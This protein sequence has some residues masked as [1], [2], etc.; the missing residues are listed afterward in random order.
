MISYQYMPRSTG[1][2]DELIAVSSKSK[3]I[4]KPQPFAPEGLLQLRAQLSRY[5]FMHL[6]SPL[7]LEGWKL[8]YRLWRR[9]CVLKSR[10]ARLSSRSKC[11]Q[12]QMLQKSAKK[13]EL[14]HSVA[15]A[16]E[17]VQRQSF[18]MVLGTIQRH[19]WRRGA[20][21]VVNRWKGFSL[22]TFNFWTQRKRSFGEDGDKQMV[23]PVKRQKQEEKQGEG[24]E[25]A[26]EK[27]NDLAKQV[28]SSWKL[29]HNVSVGK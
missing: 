29:E 12:V 3:K 9:S 16:V 7:L 23:S 13:V 1:G 11:R 19:R 10:K 24:R 2:E 17:R 5:L 25:K 20:A 4:K 28:L 8:G 27:L 26:G 6:L 21:R 22:L 18:L 15:D 14:S